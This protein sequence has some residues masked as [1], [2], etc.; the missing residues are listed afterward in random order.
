MLNPYYPGWYSFQLGCAQY[1]A[2]DYEGAVE[3]L[4]KM[5]PLGEPRRILAAGL[6]YL[7]RMDEAH[8][9]AKRFLQD[10]PSFSIS[11]WSS[12]QPFR[13][14]KDRQHAVQGYIMA[15]CLNDNHHC[16]FR[17]EMSNGNDLT[18]MPVKQYRQ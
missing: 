2:R 3:T 18:G 4:A 13:Y 5:S 15:G 6:A 16:H 8:A 17:L 14:D 12:T 10:N 9:E 11:R 1:I 7:E